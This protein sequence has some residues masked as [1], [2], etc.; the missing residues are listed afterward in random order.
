[1]KRTKRVAVLALTLAVLAG[2]VFAGGKR[3][4]AGTSA[5]SRE[6][7]IVYSGTPQ[8][9]E[10]E[11][12]IDVFVR[13]FETQHG[14]KVN[15]EFVTQQDAI[16][17]IESEQDTGNRISDVV[18]AD[19]AYLA[20]YINGGWV[21]DIGRLIHPGTTLTTMYDSTTNQNGKRLFIPNTFDVYVLAANVEAVKYLPQGLTRQDVINGITWDQYAEWAVNIAKG[22]GKGK[23][24]FPASAQGSQLLYPMAG[25]ALA[26]GGGFPDF[27]SE[28][29]KKAL[30]TIAVIARG[31]GF[32]SEQAQYTAPTDPMRSGDVWLTFA[33]MSPIGVAYNAAPNEWIIGAAPK[34]SK[35][36]GSTSGAW[37]WGVQ[38]GAPH[39]DLAALWID[40]VTT[41][42]VNYEFCANLGGMLSPVNEVGP[43][44]SSGDAVMVAGNKMLGNTIVSGVPSTDYSDWNAVKLL[45]IDAFNQTISAKQVPNNAFLQDLQTKCLALKIN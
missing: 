15:F 34:G 3:D 32:Y 40:Y 31:N 33:H 10:K 2:S 18:Y 11:Y 42:R 24:M 9:H 19:T 36:A 21:E 17:K 35:G 26:N 30:D 20:P 38:K 16:R 6:L 23:T 7:T 43:L 12:L 22:E 37:C 8:P 14:V 13:Q 27:T 28:G 4:Q 1:M 45:Y 5:G 39:A 44:L 41:P 25:M 29:F